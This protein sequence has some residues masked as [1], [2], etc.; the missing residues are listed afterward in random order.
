MSR[1]ARHSRTIGTWLLILL[2]PSIFIIAGSVAIRAAAQNRTWARESA[3][4]PQVPG[5][6]VQTVVNK[7]DV[8]TVIYQY[9]ASGRYFRSSRAVFGSVDSGTANRI[10]GRYSPG[11]TVSVFVNPDDP[12]VAVLH[13]GSHGGNWLL[14]LFGGTGIV[15]GLLMLRF[16]IKETRN[17]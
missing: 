2:F 14:P 1:R 8:R 9:A 3:S 5:T 17:G 4:W 6:I 11:Q 13:P 16:L 15:V 10:A 7:H 12:S